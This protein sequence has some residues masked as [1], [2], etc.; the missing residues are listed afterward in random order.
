MADDDGEPPKP[1]LETQAPAGEAEDAAANGEGGEGST[2]LEEAATATAAHPPGEHQEPA[3]DDVH[4]TPLDAAAGK[5]NLKD[6]DRPDASQGGDGLGAGPVVRGRKRNKLKAS[7]GGGKGHSNPRKTPYKSEIGRLRHEREMAAANGANGSGGNNGGGPRPAKPLGLSLAETNAPP[8]EASFAISAS[9]FKHDLLHGLGEFLTSAFADD[10]EASGSYF[11]QDLLDQ[12]AESSPHLRGVWLQAKSLNDVNV[13]DLCHALIRN[14]VVTEVWLP[15]NHITDVGASYIAHMLK[16]NRTIK[17]L[18]LGENDIGP[19][20]A[21]ALASALARNNNTLQ[22]LGLG[23]N[24]I[25]V[26]GAGAFAAALRHNHTLHT[27]DVKDNGIPRRSSI[28]A[29]LSKMLEFNASDPGDES[30]VLGLQEELANLVGSLPPDVAEAVVMQA[31]EA[32]KQAMLCRRRG[33]KVGAAEAEGVFIRVCTT[34]ERPRDPPSTAE[35]NMDPVEEEGEVMVGKG[36]SVKRA[37]SKG[38]EPESRLD[39]INEELSELKFEEKE[40]GKEEGEEG[41]GGDSG[42]EPLEAAAEEVAKD[43]KEE[44]VD[45]TADEAAVP[46]EPASVKAE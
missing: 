24:N 5:Q 1:T 30:L 12:L 10:E 6:A 13:R 35:L 45:E 11:S 33:D 7:A 34:G 17:E 44:G 23:N 46:S 18:F 36:K 40:E 27:L 43:G 39:G 22:A 15:G 21:A 29:L 25:G 42:K 2:A 3:M 14:R 19:K 31:E 41:G 32:L 38:L 37:D 26:E 8:P 4:L 16:F 20:G 28:R 9:R